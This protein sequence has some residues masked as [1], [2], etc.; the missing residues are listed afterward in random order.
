[1]V[2]G[3]CGAL[4]TQVSDA[5][6]FDELRAGSGGTRLCGDSEMWATR[7]ESMRVRYEFFVS[8]YVVMPEHVHLLVSEPRN[9]PLSKALQALKL[10]VA[11]RRQERPFWQSRY[12]D[13]NVFSEKKRLEKLNYMHENPVVRGLVSF[14]ENW[15]WSSA[16]HW[17]TGEVGVVEIE[18]EWTAARRERAGVLG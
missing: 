14:A 6:P 13:F 1:M 16:R 2:L 3:V 7:L 15:R 4:E 10:A 5:R 11:V 17:V 9:A 18:S 12:H 8:G